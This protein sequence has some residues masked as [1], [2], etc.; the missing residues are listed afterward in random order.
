MPVLRIEAINENCI[1]GLWEITES[2]PELQEQLY[3]NFYDA[4]YIK[5]TTHPVKQTEA[6]AVRLLAQHMLSYWG[7]SYKGICKDAHDKPYLAGSTYH[8]SLSHTHGYAG[9]IINKYQKVGIDIEFTKEKLNKIANKFLSEKE[10][11][12]AN[13]GLEKLC[14]YWCAKEA[15]YKKYGSKQVSFKE[16]IFIDPF[17]LSEEG[18]ITGRVTKEGNEWVS[19]INYLKISHLHLTIAY[20]FG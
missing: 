8:I 4:A 3:A 15:L 11:S 9:V 18:T 2:T 7:F 16:Q 13:G 1:W 12:D 17:I 20:S 19:K 14:V 10:L 6:L 5:T